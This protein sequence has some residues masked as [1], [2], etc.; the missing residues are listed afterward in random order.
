MADLLTRP[1]SYLVR[2]GSLSCEYPALSDP[3]LSQ[4]GIEQARAVGEFFS[5]DGFGEIEC[6]DTVAARQFVGIIMDSGPVMKYGLPALH[7]IAGVNPS[8]MPVK[9]GG[10]VAVYVTDKKTE[11]VP[12]LNPID[13]MSI[14]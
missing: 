5:V 2:L 7:I 11:Y 14:N 10:I 6:P 12:R 3:P 8:V 9:A 1:V 13:S 4:E